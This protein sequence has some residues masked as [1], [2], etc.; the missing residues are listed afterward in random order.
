METSKTIRALQLDLALGRIQ[1]GRGPEVALDADMAETLRHLHA[2]AAR[3]VPD[4]AFVHRLGQRLVEE[5]TTAERIDQAKPGMLNGH[6]R[7]A[8]ALPLHVPRPQ[9]RYWWRRLEIAAAMLVI[10]VLGGYFALLGYGRPDSGQQ[11]PPSRIVANQSAEHVEPVQ[12][13]I[14]TLLLEAPVKRRSTVVS[15]TAAPGA[16]VSLALVWKDGERVL[17]PVP[18][19][20]WAA[21]WHDDLAD[22]ND[23]GNLV[24]SAG[25]PFWSSMPALFDRLPDLETGDR[26]DITGADGREYPYD[27]EWKRTFVA[28]TDDQNQEIYGPTGS[29]SLTLIT[30]TGDVDHTTGR[31]AD[32]LVVRAHQVEVSP[33]R[34]DGASPVQLRI[35]AIG[36]D[37]PIE[38][39]Q[40][41]GDDVATPAADI[42]TVGWRDDKPIAVPEP[43]RPWDIAWQDDSPAP[44]D[45]SN[46]VLRGHLDD[47]D[48]GNAV[49]G[50][51]K[52]LTEGDRI[53]VTRDD[54][55]VFAYAVEWSR[56]FP[57]DAG[58]DALRD[59]LGPTTGESL[60]LMTSAGAFDMETM[61][62]PEVLIVRARFLGSTSLRTVFVPDPRECQTGPRTVA[63]LEAAATRVRPAP[64][65]EPSATAVADQTG[66]AVDAATMNAVIATEREL[67]ACLNA[68]DSLRTYALYTDAGLDRLMQWV[69]PLSETTDLTLEWAP[70]FSYLNTPTP[71][72]PESERLALSAVDDVRRLPDG[73]IAALVTIGPGSADIFGV[74]TDV[75]VLHIFAPGERLLIDEFIVPDLPTRTG[76]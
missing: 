36:V 69:S 35:D 27:V 4:S 6:A 53:D 3:P 52:E 24:L 8:P 2:L 75:P 5:A 22:L 16:D 74:P 19:D 29:E 9:P 30:G 18:S 39:S 15:P 73:R 32:V 49:F 38:S 44:G 28:S 63:M 60:T 58:E 43:P 45:G 42:G 61:N 21:S 76:S 72:R 59:I 68:S 10:A 13:R 71:P 41:S 40:P 48:T 14:D 51:L 70:D 56:R 25:T 7:P 20:N 65:P 64:R 23:G 11:Q 47:W 54:G 33:P 46:V 34:P 55:D 26:I 12:I 37:A 67:V 31:Y 66:S 50:D 1:D 57:I 17:A 62:Y